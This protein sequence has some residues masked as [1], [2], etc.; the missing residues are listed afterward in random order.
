MKIH[1]FTVVIL[2]AAVT[3][4][5]VGSIAGATFLGAIGVALELWFWVRVLRPGERRLG[6]EQSQSPL[7]G[8]AMSGI[9]TPK[10]K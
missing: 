1:V 10:A 6:I 3:M 2:I 7:T 4:Y 9:S 8:S 5:G